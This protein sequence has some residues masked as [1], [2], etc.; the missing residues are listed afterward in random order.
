MLRRCFRVTR[1]LTTKDQRN[2]WDTGCLVK[3]KLQNNY[4]QGLCQVKVSR[5]TETI[6]NKKA[7]K[8]YGRH[9]VRVND[10]C[11]LERSAG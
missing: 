4:C 9:Y 5:D 1:G 6:R 10:R 11:K 2:R 8:V 7:W 3:V